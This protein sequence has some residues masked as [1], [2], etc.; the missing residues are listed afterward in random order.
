MP[1]VEAS[2]AIRAPREEIFALAQDYY[3]RLE[4]DPFLREMKFLEGATEA[5]LGVRVMVR[6]WNRMSME[7]RYV[8][9]DEPERVA[10]VMTKGPF[11]FESFAGSWRFKELGRGETEVTFRYHFATRWSALRPLLDAIIHRVF[12]R[13]IRKRLQ[14]LKDAIDGG[15]RAPA[16]FD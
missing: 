16:I 1:I 4:W 12:T 2:I 15:M 10:V 13:D 7:V 5:G 14:G 6:A 11:F 8:T 9:L 3:L